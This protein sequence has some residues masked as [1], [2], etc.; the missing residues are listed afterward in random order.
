M[1]QTRSQSRSKSQRG[2]SQEEEREELDVDASNGDEEEFYTIDPAEFQAMLSDARSL[3]CLSKH[4]ATTATLASLTTEVKAAQQRCDAL[5]K[6]LTSLRRELQKRPRGQDETAERDDKKKR[7]RTESTDASDGAPP[8]GPQAAAFFEALTRRLER[9][10]ESEDDGAKSLRAAIIEVSPGLKA[11]PSQVIMH[12]PK[13]F[14]EPLAWLLVFEN[15]VRDNFFPVGSSVPG[16]RAQAF[17]L[18]LDAWIS[19]E[20]KSLGLKNESEVSNRLF[21]IFRELSIAYFDSRGSR[22]WRDLLFDLQPNLQTAYDM[23]TEIESKW[24]EVHVSADA[25]KRFKTNV[26]LRGQHTSCTF[27]S[28]MKVY[29]KKD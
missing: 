20:P 12:H 10:G 25:A 1:V 6:E 5:T 9:T 11:L 22:S 16:P 14:K 3:R 29:Q 19:G 17:K 27:A 21:R 15:G 23:C 8:S 26:Q 24:I 28:C 4:F 13:Y 2:S 7:V 18:L